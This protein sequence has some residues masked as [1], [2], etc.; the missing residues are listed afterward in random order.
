M[1]GS[2]EEHGR[3]TEMVSVWPFVCLAV[4]IESE[5]CCYCWESFVVAVS[6]DEWVTVRMLVP[7]ILVWYCE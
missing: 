4:R 5:R 2:H 7:Y 3:T 6:Q 1:G